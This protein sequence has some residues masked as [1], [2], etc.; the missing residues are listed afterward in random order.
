MILLLKINNTKEKNIKYPGA[1][2][3]WK[4]NGPGHPE[5]SLLR[6]LSINN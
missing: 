4:E 6:V 2:V 1:T 5:Y 3:K